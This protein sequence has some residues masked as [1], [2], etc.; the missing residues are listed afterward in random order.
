M[1]DLKVN[2]SFLKFFKPKSIQ[3]CGQPKSWVD[4]PGW[5]EFYN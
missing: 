4:L 3:D 5:T 1:Y 2:K